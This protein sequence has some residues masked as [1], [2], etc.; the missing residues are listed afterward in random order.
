MVDTKRYLGR[1]SHRFTKD[2][3]NL[4]IQLSIELE[5]SKLPRS[6]P[7]VGTFLMLNSGMNLRGPA[8]IWWRISNITLAI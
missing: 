3:T 5:G 4:N 8:S 1:L 7:R 2:V 6:P